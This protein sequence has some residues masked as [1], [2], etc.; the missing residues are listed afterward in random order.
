MRPSVTS[1][2]R[3][4]R[5]LQH[6]Q[7]RRELVQ[8][9]HPVGLRTLPAHDAHDV[10]LQLAGI[11]NA[12]ELVLR[13]EHPGRRFDHV[14]VVGNGRDLDDSAP[15][16]AGQQLEAAG[17]AEGLGGRTHDAGVARRADVAPHDVAVERRLARVLADAAGPH[18]EHVLVH[19]PGIQQLADHEAGPA[20]GLELVHIRAPVRIHPGQQ[21]HHG[22]ELRKVVPVDG[23]AG[24]ARDR[25]P[26]DQVIGR[27]AGGHQRAHRID[28]GALVHQPPDRRVAR[29]LHDAQRRAHGLPRQ[30]LA[31]F[32][33][34][35]DERRAR[36]VQAHRL[37]QHLVAVGRAVEGAGARC[38]V[39]A[40]FGIQQLGP[41]HPPLRRLF[42][43]LGLVVVRQAAGHRAARHEHGGQMAELQGP[44][45]EARHDLVA[46]AQ[47]QRS[48]EHV[49]A[50]G[51]RG[52]HGDHVAREQA[53][54]HAR[55]AL[56]DAVAHGRHPAGNLG[57]GAA[58]PGL[59]LDQVRVTGERRVR[60]QHVV[61][62]GDDADVGPLLRDHAQLVVGRQAREGVRD[63][64]ATQPVGSAVAR[65]RLVE[66][67]Q[68]LA[69][70][71]RTALADALGDGAQNRVEF[72]RDPATMTNRS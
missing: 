2:T 17:G 68:V 3:K 25:H 9:G 21:R 32:I 39:S 14:T 48:V 50:E 31:Q 71:R 15:E 72:H 69:A 26:V 59:V 38:V 42:A 47:Q 23:D 29:S 53:Q 4:P 34:R 1:A 27:T 49:V 40:H 8:L 66:L 54:L 35:V 28:D 44:D 41:P 56:R 51:D 60:R 67:P 46:D 70:G 43:H 37:H 57:G 13:I 11:E 63:V 18:R 16:V 19:Q 62:R 22:R 20:R 58:L 36:H 65:R 45:Q 55:R 6:G 61:V 10:A 7:R 5:A 24:R 33:A 52:G 12:Q 30:R 64:G